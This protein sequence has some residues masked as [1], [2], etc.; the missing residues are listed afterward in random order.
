MGSSLPIVASH[1]MR[2]SSAVTASLAAVCAVRS[3]GAR[4]RGGPDPPV[5]RLYVSYT[6]SN[7]CA[8]GLALYSLV[9]AA[10]SCSRVAL[11]NARIN[12]RLCV[13]A[14]LNADILPRITVHE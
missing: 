3:S 7:T 11:R 13:V 14:L 10:I 9:S 6:S 12:L 2:R 5:T 4:L 1:V 8:N